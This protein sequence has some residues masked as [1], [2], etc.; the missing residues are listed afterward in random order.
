MESFNSVIVYAG[1]KVKAGYADA[2]IER[3]REVV[4]C[5][6]AEEG[7][8]RY[9]LVRDVLDPDAF[10]FFEE[11]RDDATFAAHRE[12]PYMNPFREFRAGVVDKYLG[13]STLRRE[14]V[15]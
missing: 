4:E 6:R 2:F 11:Y 9:D 14:S 10:Y 13:V 5:T 1:L 12:M 3:A 8:L 7:C 15:R